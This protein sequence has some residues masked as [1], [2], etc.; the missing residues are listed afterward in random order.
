VFH[1]RQIDKSY[2]GLPADRLRCVIDWVVAT[3][4]GG[5]ESMPHWDTDADSLS[6]WLL[7]L[8][9]GKLVPVATYISNVCGC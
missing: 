7:L 1:S 6:L 3:D 8:Y 4:E 9:F 5:L 2:I